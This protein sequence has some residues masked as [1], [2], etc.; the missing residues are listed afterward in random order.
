MLSSTDLRA[1]DLS[2]EALE[3]ARNLQ[4]E[5]QLRQVIEFRSKLKTN[6]TEKPPLELR[7]DFNDAKEECVEALEQ[8]RLEIEFVQAELKVE[9]AGSS[10]LMQAYGYESNRKANELNVRSF[11]LNG[12]LWQ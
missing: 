5:S 8:A 3:L 2:N 4:I 7:A 11:R 1:N 9:I 12:A 6:S 10:E